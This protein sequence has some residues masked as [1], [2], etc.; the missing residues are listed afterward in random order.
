MVKGGA[1]VIRDKTE[2]T[3]ILLA[4]NAVS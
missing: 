2:W 3:A 1:K 4:L